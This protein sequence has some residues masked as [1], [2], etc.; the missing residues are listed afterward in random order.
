MGC[1]IRKAMLKDA[2]EYA[3]C[4]ISSW[5]SAYKGIVPDE[6]L[7]SLS[8]EQKTERFRQNV[9]EPNGFDYYCAVDG[10][11]II[12]VLI[13]G[14]SRDDDKP[15]AGEITAIYLLEEFWSRGFGKGMMRYAMD[16]LKCMGHH[17]GIV[18][19]LE[20]NNRARRFY[21]KCGFALD[22]AKMEIEL[23]KPLTVVRYAM[24]L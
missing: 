1:T 3:A 12:G 22:G 17:E 11:K 16:A 6:Y 15:D 5:R 10:G 21:E 18:W 4:H 9:A 24:I 20:E 7:D 23:A 2:H 8:A 13:I 14:P 19:V